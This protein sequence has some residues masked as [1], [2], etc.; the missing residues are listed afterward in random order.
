MRTVVGQVT[1]TI[2]TGVG[3]DAAAGPIDVAVVDGYV[4]VSFGGT[5]AFLDE[6]EAARLIIAVGKA[7]AETS[8]MAHARAVVDEAELGIRFP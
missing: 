1:A 5:W 3:T 6:V 4:E 7:W 2:G 8:A